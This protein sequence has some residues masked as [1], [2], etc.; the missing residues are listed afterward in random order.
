MNIKHLVA[1]CCVYCVFSTNASEQSLETLQREADSVL[2]NPD[3][4]VRRSQVASV[5]RLA[6]RLTALGETNKAL[7]YYHSALEHEPWNLP[8]Q[9]AVADLLNKI[10]KTAEAQQKAELVWNYAETDALLSE[11]AKLL[12]KSFSVEIPQDE[13]SPSASNQ[14]VLVPVGNIEVWLLLE[15][16]NELKNLLGFPVLIQPLSVEIP[17][18]ARD[19]VHLRAE[20]LRQRLEKA[21]E[22]PEFRSLLNKLDLKLKSSTSDDEVFAFT[23]AVLRSERDK[24]PLRRFTEELAFLRRLG[25]QW[26]ASGLLTNM[27]KAFSPKPGSGVGYLAVTKMDLFASDSRYVF[28]LAGI[29]SNCGIFSYHRFTAAVLDTPP[30]RERLKQRVLKQALSS[31]GLLFGLKRCTDPTCARAYVNDLAEHD[32]KRLILC[33]ECLQG[34]AKRFTERN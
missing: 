21:Q 28:G 20:D 2:N 10:D 11:A 24:E 30:N 1:L 18:P 32:A 15:L 14:L 13:I 19:A 31:T 7:G 4:L 29:G 22:S 25:P 16:R 9:L 6:E 26:D 34:F 33:A 3:N 17:Q 23:E 5:F 27:N 12:N 8:A